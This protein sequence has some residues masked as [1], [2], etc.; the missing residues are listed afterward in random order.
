ME[1]GLK[2]AIEDV[3]SSLG[4]EAVDFVVEHPADLS[5]GDYSTNVA[6][7]AGG[8]PREVAEK[9][10]EGLEGKVKMVDR[11]EIAGPGFINFYLKPEFFAEE[12]KKI[13]KE[14]EKYGK[15]KVGKGQKVIVEY[16]SPNIAKPF[17]VGHLRSTIIGDAVA[18]IYEYTGHT[19]LRDNHLGDWGTQFGKLIVAIQ[20]WGNEEEIG[21]SDRPVKKLVDLYVKFHEEAENDESLNDEAREWFTKLEAGDKEARYLW[22]KCVDWSMVE[23]D[24]IY[25]RLGIE[26]DMA[27]GE[28]FVEDKM[29]VVVEELEEKGLLKESEGAK[30]VFFEDEKYPPLMILKKDGSSLYGTR[31]L[32]IDRYRREKWGKDV[33]VINEAGSEQSLYFRQLYETE[34]MLGWYKE[35][36]RIFVGHGL[37]SFKDGK[38]STRKGNVIWLEEV[39]DEA[40]KRAEELSEDK[41][42]ARKVGLGALK[43][44]DLKREAMKNIVFDWDEIL[45]LKGDSGPYLQYTYAR[46]Q[47][48]LDKAKD[49]GVK[50][51]A[52]L[53]SDWKTTDVEKM[54]YRFPEIVLHALREQGPHH[55]CIY[56]LDLAREFNSWYGNTQIV[57]KGDESSRYKVS[58]AESVAVVIQ[59]GLAILGVEVVE[60][61]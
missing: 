29:D 6:M 44:N 41:E 42:V 33:V 46:I 59:N 51:K 25:K 23:F 20:K 2:K 3:V 32:A 40:V 12:T 14:G 27:L 28:S 60:R 24:Q 37:Y 35:G 57:D 55:I 4:M 11:V 26:F 48:I 50:A 36:Q 15:S 13:V 45:D 22:Q 7:K 61:M 18:N 9:I 54:V 21:E 10:V 31:D 53:P 8:N 19:V 58:V 52:K 30:L 38:M 43:F 16:S 34:S 39:L 56:L 1:E 47:S 17:T 49:E 5:H